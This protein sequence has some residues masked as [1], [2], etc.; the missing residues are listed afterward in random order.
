MDAC[1]AIAQ[2]EEVVDTVRDEGNSL[3][4]TLILGTQ[5]EISLLFCDTS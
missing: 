5:R 1:C 2:L 4:Q 3:Q